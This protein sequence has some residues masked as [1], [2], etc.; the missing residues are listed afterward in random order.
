VKSS[1]HHILQSP[2]KLID[3]GLHFNNAYKSPPVTA[4]DVQEY[5]LEAAKVETRPTPVHP[6]PDNPAMM[7]I[8]KKRGSRPEKITNV[9]EGEKKKR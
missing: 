1:L 6:T 4:G 2:Q 5:S 7:P 9:K 3:H 8:V